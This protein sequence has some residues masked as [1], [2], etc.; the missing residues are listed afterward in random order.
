MPRLALAALLLTLL[1]NVAGCSIATRIPANRFD[2]PET[3][4]KR[5]SGDFGGGFEGGNEYVITDDDTATPPNFSNPYFETS[6]WDG[7]L[8]GN[9]GILSCLDVG[10]K[11]RTNSTTLGQVKYQ[12]LGEPRSAAKEGNFS[13]AVSAAGGG[14]TQS[15]SDTSIGSNPTTANNSMNESAVDLATVMGY[16]MSDRALL[17]WSFSWT[18]QTY[19]GT[20]TQT[21][22]GGQTYYYSGQLRQLGFNVGAEFDDANFISRLE[23]ATARTTA[24]GGGPTYTDVY[25]GG[26]VGFRW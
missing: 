13:L 22:G 5:W 2:S 8:N 17:Y 21:G 24:V 14:S 7:F 12:I 10:V 11:I 25:G 20:L 6:T 1:L 19:S 15:G 9:L 26:E 23:L 3:V 4:G 18:R 16:R